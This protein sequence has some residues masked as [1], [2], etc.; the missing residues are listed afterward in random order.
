MTEPSPLIDMTQPERQTEC[1]NELVTLGDW[2]RFAAS[3]MGAYAVFHGHGFESAWDEA[4]FLCLRGVNLDWDAPPKVLDGRL[5][6]TERAHLLSLVTRRCVERVPTAYLLGEAWYCG[7]PFKVSPNVLIPRSPIA[8]LIEAEF[9]P[10]LP[11]APESVLDLCTG[12]GCIGIAM[13][14]VFPDAAVHLSDLSEEAV[15][16][17]VDNVD[18]K[19]L[20]WQVNVFQGDLF[21]PLVGQRYDLIVSNP[22]YVDVDDLDTMP[23]EFHHEPRLGLAAGEDGLDIVRRILREAPD[24][25]TDDG[26]LVCEVGNS[27][28]AL[29]EA[30]PELPFEWPV[31]AN[32]GHGVFIIDAGALRA[33]APA[34][35]EG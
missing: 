15:R 6:S 28:G 26:V 33:Y 18:A 22:P 31:F 30:F 9:A 24:H 3:Q 12:S 23:E 14:R 29:M 1:L 2:V 8:E 27:A 13:A 19:D 4:V 11:H 5:L 17:A 25:L 32:G 7:E 35:A 16:L 21:E 10:W 34:L 20:G